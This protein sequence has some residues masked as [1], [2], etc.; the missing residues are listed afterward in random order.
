[1]VMTCELEATAVGEMLSRGGAVIDCSDF[2]VVCCVCS[3]T[4]GETVNGASMNGN[5]A[6]LH[7]DGIPEDTLKK[8]PVT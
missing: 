2:V 5:S 1:M 6:T 4:D 3:R 7:T 8:V